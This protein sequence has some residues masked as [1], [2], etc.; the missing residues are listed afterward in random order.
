MATLEKIPEET[1]RAF[2][3]K[4]GIDALLHLIQI[5][6]AIDGTD[7]EKA[8]LV[9]DP[10]ENNILT[11]DSDGDLQDSGVALP[12]GDIVGTTDTQTLSAKTLT[13]PTVADLTNMTHDHTDDAGGGEITVGEAETQ[14]DAA[15]SESHSITDPA[16]TPADADALRDDLVTNALSEIASALDALGA[17]FNT[18]FNDL[19]DKLQAAGLME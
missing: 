16:D 14:D 3:D 6:V 4:V 19:L 1:A 18:K 2:V 13:T 11:A 15:A 8:N 17:E 12:D 7:G 5:K 9:G 10:T